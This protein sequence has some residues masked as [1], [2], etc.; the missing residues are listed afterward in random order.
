MYLGIIIFLLSS[1]FNAKEVNTYNLD[2]L[3]IIETTS[4]EYPLIPKRIKSLELAYK[5]LYF[6]ISHNSKL[7]IISE[8]NIKRHGHIKELNL[9]DKTLQITL[10]N[11]IL[12]SF[13]VDNRG[14][15][16]T[17]N[18]S[19]PKVTPPIKE[20]IL[21]IYLNDNYTIE[22]NELS[23]KISNNREEFHLK[24]NDNYYL[25]PN[26][27]N[28]HIKAV[29]DKIST[30]TFSP[31]S[32]SELPLAEQWYLLN[33]LVYTE[34][35]DIAISDYLYKCELYINSLFSPINY[36]EDY[37]TWKNLPSINEFTEDSVISYLALGMNNGSYQRNLEKIKPLKDRYPNMFTYASTPFLGNILKNGGNGMREEN[38]LRNKIQSYINTSDSRLNK[39]W[40]PQY[41][42]KGQE[43]NVKA[44]ESMINSMNKED[45]NLEELS[46]ALYNLLQIMEKESTNSKSIDS[47]KE[48]TDL[49]LQ[50]IKWDDS[51]IYLSDDRILTNQ[52]LNLKVGQLLIDASQYEASEYSKPIAE[53][54]IH[55]YLNNSNKDGEV[56]TT[57]N[58]LEKS[59]SDSTVSAE[60]SFLILSDNPYL[61]HYYQSDGIKIWTISDSIAI[62][63][64]TKNIR[65]TITY[66]VDNNS[67][68]NSH[69]L[70]VSGIKPYSQLYFKGTLW[71]ADKLFERYGVG[72]Y[73]ENS[74]ELL[75]FMP[76]HTKPREEI[77]I[78]Y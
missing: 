57:Y 60:K 52:E 6:T 70:T 29:D 78:T 13:R 58:L 59:F 34:K 39:L 3:G 64:S 11:N 61:P 51:G 46:I 2:G 77:V 65:I 14:E 15:R 26:N 47:V 56:K 18:S 9:I 74:T 1:Y 41:L 22:K 5:G 38:N 25:G 10:D 71:R 43:L 37:N 76:N 21:P 19:I 55:T 8:D 75:Y 36:Q 17:V 53:G 33:R 16:L 67:K 23:Y 45:L 24:L 28:I 73:Y 35:L 68:V 62:N 69:F 42:F 31:L 72:Y 66:P 54:L 30:L 12:L 7:I 32:D 50:K 4:V 48:I 63:K 49:I 40:I 20:I 44:L 27:S